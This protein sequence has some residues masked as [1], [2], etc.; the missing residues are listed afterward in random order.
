MEFILLLMVSVIP[1]IISFFILF[2]SRNSLSK[3]LSLFLCML[4]FWQIDIAILYA[5]ELMNIEW[6]ER[7]FRFFRMGTIFIMPIMYY[8]SYHLV[9]MN[10]ELHNFRFLFNKFLLYILTFYSLIVYIINFTTAGIKYFY[11]N[12]GNVLSS[13][14]FLPFYG[15]M[16]ILFLINIIFVYINTFFL[17]L[18]TVKL[19]DQTYKKFYTRLVIVAII[20]FI[21]GVMSG[22]SFIPLFFSIFNSII[23]AL[24]LFLGF[25]QMQSLRIN[26]MNGELIRQSELL[27]AIMNINPNFLLVKNNKD[28]IVKMNSS[29]SQLISIPKEDL[30]G[31]DF[32]ILTTKINMLHTQTEDA[33]RYVDSKGQVYY[34]LWGK[35]KILHSNGEV[36]QIYFGIDVTEQKRNEQLLLSSEKLKVIGEMAASVAHEIRNPLTTIR[37]FIQLLK[38]QKNN[39]GYESILL[40]EID[41]INDV[42]KELLILGKPEATQDEKNASAPVHLLTELKNIKLLFQ[43]LAIEQNKEIY[44]EN[45]GKK[46][47]LVQMEKS[48]F[49]QVMINFIKN[50]LE[51]ISTEK[52]KIKI[53]LD[54]KQGIHRIR[55]LDNG[56][57]I[58][59]ERLARIGEPYYTS[60]EKGTGIGLTICFK[61][62]KENNG[63][64]YVKSKEGWGTCV[65]M[66]LPSQ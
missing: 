58:S 22:F 2:F 45:R 59:K 13:D 61:L 5:D 19:K 23:A 49:K 38:E 44:L 6:I 16:N 42:L 33:Y 35:K 26:D 10:K 9:R 48:H 63:E 1:L 4:S 32:S 20:I 51:A 64:V 14:Y 27:E 21:N 34:I 54:T 30:L 50:S 57:G 36:Y 53:I 12:K 25:V 41:R 7:I 43:A 3:A 24:I 47:A 65:T 11:L 8:F 55:I 60:K 17:L 31:K 29:F 37:G 56:N 40:E 66:T 46:V 52:G 39:S 18:I 15:E 28:Q 62:L